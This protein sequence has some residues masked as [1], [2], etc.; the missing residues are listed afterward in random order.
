MERDKIYLTVEEL[1]DVVYNESNEYNVI[2]S[3][4]T[5]EWRHG[6]EETTIVQHVISNKFFKICWRSS[7]KDECEFLDMNDAG[8]YAEVFPAQK[9]VTVYE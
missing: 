2:K 9:T 1:R 7:V 3:E 8:N 6:S 4:T 5:G